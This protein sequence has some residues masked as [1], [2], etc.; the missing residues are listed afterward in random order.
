MQSR[1]RGDSGAHGGE[2]CL[3][4]SACRQAVVESRAQAHASGASS[5]GAL[6]R[7]PGRCRSS[8]RCSARDRQMCRVQHV[9]VRGAGRVESRG[10]RVG[11]ESTQ[12][13]GPSSSPRVRCPVGR[14]GLLASHVETVTSRVESLLRAVPN[15]PPR[16]ARAQARSWCTARGNIGNFTAVCASLLWC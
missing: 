12:V 14:V 6:A 2:M 4:S 5:R 3:G 13:V 7:P 8:S 11:V 10:T 15:A 9:G 16:C 1:A